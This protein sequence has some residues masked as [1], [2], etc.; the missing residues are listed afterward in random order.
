[1]RIQ[2]TTEAELV[3]LL[4]GPEGNASLSPL[5]DCAGLVIELG[6]DAESAPPGLGAALARL[7]CVSVGFASTLPRA[8]AWH[9]AL[10]ALVLD[11]AEPAVAEGWVSNGDVEDAA[12]ELLRSVSARP[13][14]A[15]AQATLLRG[16]AVEDVWPAL[17]AESASYSTLLGGEE[18][19]E[20]RR[21]T[22]APRRD[23][24]REPTLRV[25]RDGEELRI[26]L[27][28]PERRNAF[29]R[30]SREE[31]IEALRV[32][33]A[34]PS[35]AVVHLRGEG[36]SFCAGGDLAEFGDAG[37]PA[38]AHAV[39]L[40]QHPGW[41]MH[42]IG[43]RLRV[44][45][46]GDCVGAGVELAAFAAEVE[47]APGSRFRLPEVSMGLLPGAGGTVS[48]R[49]RIGRQRAAFLGLS[50]A[51]LGVETALRWG[52]VDRLEAP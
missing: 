38:L 11:A 41:W 35:I 37:D 1:M 27:D 3:D 8:Q 28:R 16:A 45:V 32:A 20:W 43:D 12:G 21:G 9:G 50:G 42:A 15:L 22:P 47:A 10:D 34:D 2:R 4:L 46:H 44:R 19:H 30:R 13:F 17:V 18:Y 6:G 24:R 39:R 48:V 31:L 5:Q 29:G 25:R 14:A 26:V 40:A 51:W 36:P 7:P 23:R 33:A 49:R 52:L